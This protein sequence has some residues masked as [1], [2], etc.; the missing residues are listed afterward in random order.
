VTLALTRTKIGGFTPVIFICS[1][2]AAGNQLRLA[3]ELAKTATG[4][5]LRPVSSYVNAALS[6]EEQDRIMGRLVTPLAPPVSEVCEFTAFDE[7][8]V[9]P[10]VGSTPR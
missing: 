10:P 8:T 5:V 9:A 3:T 1:L 4:F 6:F 2:R 7:R